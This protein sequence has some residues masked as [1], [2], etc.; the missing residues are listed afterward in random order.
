MYPSV[1]KPVHSRILMSVISS[2]CG[3]FHQ[4]FFSAFAPMFSR[5]KKFKPKM[6]VQKSFAQNICIKPCVKCWC[7]DN[8][9]LSVIPLF[10]QYVLMSD[11]LY[12]YPS[13]QHYVCSSVPL[14]ICFRCVK[15]SMTYCPK[16]GFFLEIVN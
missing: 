2:A 15:L 6:S 3:Q 1:C 4:H 7:I 11:R 10:C 12:I 8:C 9:C 5:Q 16:R 14:F 13:V